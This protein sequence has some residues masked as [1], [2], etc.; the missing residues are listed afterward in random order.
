MCDVPHPAIWR[1]RRLS[2]LKH[3]QKT[4]THPGTDVHW[5][6]KVKTDRVD[7]LL[8]CLGHVREI[9]LHGKGEERGGEERRGEEGRGEKGR[10]EERRGERMPC[11]GKGV[12]MKGIKH[13]T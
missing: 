10:E 1:V 9:Q 3:T 11:R 8:G 13:T 7:L 2:S 5:N 6:F 12:G 4:Y